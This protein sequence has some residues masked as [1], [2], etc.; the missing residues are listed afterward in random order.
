M[1]FT[2]KSMK[3]ILLLL[4]LLIIFTGCKKSIDVLPE[5]TQSGANTFGLKLNGEFWV[6]QKFAGINAPVLKAQLAGANINDIMITAQNFASEPLES[7]FT[8]YIKNVTGPGV[9]ELN[10]NTDIYPGVLGSYAYYVRRKINPLNEWIT[11]AQNTGSVTITK[12]DLTNNIVSGTF[13]FK[14]GSIDNSSEP[15]NI[16]DGRFDIRL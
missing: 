5:P 3:N 13:E 6:P 12:W 7:Q 16:T 8:L 2:K 9:Y 10:Q 11:S 14:A 4:S 15:I 1:V